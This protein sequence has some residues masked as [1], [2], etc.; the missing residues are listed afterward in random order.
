MTSWWRIASV[1]VSGGRFFHYVR[2]LYSAR[3][4]QSISALEPPTISRIVTSQR[5]SWKSFAEFRE[6]CIGTV[7]GVDISD[8]RKQM[9]PFLRRAV[10]FAHFCLRMPLVST[11]SAA[12]S[13]SA[14]D[15]ILPLFSFFLEKDAQIFWWSYFY[16]FFRRM[17][18]VPRGTPTSDL[19]C[20]RLFHRTDLS[21]EKVSSKKKKNR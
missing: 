14:G 19:W 21:S 12:G 17:W 15:Y 4:L 13:S 9:L 6:E 11:N 7:V 18:T 3:L 8:I 20:N 16:C 1:G 2:S 5:N 10:L